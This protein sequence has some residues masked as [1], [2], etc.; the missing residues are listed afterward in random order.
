MARLSGSSSPQRQRVASRLRDDALGTIT[1]ASTDHC[2]SCSQPSLSIGNSGSRVRE[3]SAPLAA[4]GI[5]ILYQSSYMSDFIFVKESRLAEVMQ[6]LDANGFSLYNS[7]PHGL[8]TTSLLDDL[9]EGQ[10]AEEANVYGYSY[11]G[12]PGTASPHPRDG[13]VLSRTRSPSLASLTALSL[14][15]S[16]SATLEDLQAVA[17]MA[18]LDLKLPS[19]L[20][21][22]GATSP[23]TRTPKKSMSPTA[24]PVEV[25]C[26]DIACVGLTES[27]ADVWG[28]KI[29][30]LVGY[31]ELI[32]SSSASSPTSARNIARM[33]NSPLAESFYSSAFSNPRIRNAS[34]AP[35]G[36]SPTEDMEHTFG[37]DDALRTKRF[38]VG[39]ADPSSS[40]SS[41]GS[42]SSCSSD[43]DEEEYFSSSS[44]YTRTRD[45][46]AATLS[47]PSLVSSVSQSSARSLPERLD[48]HY[49]S[50]DAR[51]ALRRFQ[52]ERRRSS[53]SKSDPVDLEQDKRRHSSASSS[54]SRSRVTTRS[55]SRV[56]FFSFTRTAEGSSLTTDLGV[57]A[58]LFG[59]EERHMLISQGGILD[60]G[61]E[62]NEEAAAGDHYRRSSDS[63]D[64]E[65]DGDVLFEQR[66][67]VD[68]PGTM[69]CLQIDL[70]KF[71]LG[72][73]SVS[74][75]RLL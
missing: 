6:L 40:S 41:P 58:A 13:A 18:K 4:A 14:A 34:P 29:L 74:Y 51:S 46:I 3:L 5:S 31:P 67:D 36:L 52:A 1:G 68:A 54:E 17:A 30:T 27:A 44:H 49:R 63:D 75:L 2:A 69:K 32:P 45:N 72:E 42:L 66:D 21:L 35:E 12:S 16:R 64:F 10:L 39:G 62:L 65:L 22:S 8:G 59:P 60:A 7:D 28:I 73:F 9:P 47:T 50:G 43:E 38:V 15:M 24:A 48:M 53:S 19:D 23:A 25:L 26:P 61:D 70:R 33:D 57:L 20:D 55:A 56:P 71:G 37:V 11:P